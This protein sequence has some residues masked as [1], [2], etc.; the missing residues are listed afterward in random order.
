MLAG[1]GGKLDPTQG[2]A[3]AVFGKGRVLGAWNLKEL[4]DASLEEA[5]LFLVGRCSCRLKNDNPGWDLLMNVD[6]PQALARAGESKGGMTSEPDSPNTAQLQ[7]AILQPQLP[8]TVI[9][10]PIIKPEKIPQGPILISISALLLAVALRL[11]R[12]KS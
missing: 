10:T 9:A 5:C 2:F 3:A 8:E 12:Q 6:W 11:I 7:A 4:D 1:P